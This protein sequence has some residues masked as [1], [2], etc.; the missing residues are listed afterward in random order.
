MDRYRSTKSGM[1]RVVPHTTI[2]AD[3]ELWVRE[4]DAEKLQ[5]RVRELE[6][7]AKGM[8]PMPKVE[9]T[10][11]ASIGTCVKMNDTWIWHE[12]DSNTLAMDSGLK[13]K[14]RIIQA[15]KGG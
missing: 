3:A 9:V 6:E 8:I 4:S 13:Y 2:E 14:N 12:V 11:D 5:A 15:L 10:Q 1:F 7:Q